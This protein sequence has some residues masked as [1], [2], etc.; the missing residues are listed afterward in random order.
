VND[1]AVTR[2]GTA[3]ISRAASDPAQNTREEIPYRAKWF[4]DSSFTKLETRAS[5]TQ[6]GP[7]SLGS[8]VYAM[9]I[10]HT[11]VAPAARSDHKHPL[12]SVRFKI[13]R[14][15]SGP[16]FG[17]SSEIFFALDHCRIA[18]INALSCN[19]E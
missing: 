13:R 1:R 19:R 10:D 4:H 2:P 3:L 9:W 15:V 5:K 18:M 16:R 7:V 8:N 14:S 11:S 17:T 12:V 6:P